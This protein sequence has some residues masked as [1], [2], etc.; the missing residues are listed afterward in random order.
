MS[1]IGIRV[2]HGL[3]RVVGDDTNWYQ[4]ILECSMARPS[5]SRML[6]I[7]IKAMVSKLSLDGPY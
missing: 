6:Q 3:N 1:Q 4:S 2:Y 5:W 7:G